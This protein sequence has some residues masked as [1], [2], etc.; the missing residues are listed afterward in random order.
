M[1][2]FCDMEVAEGSIPDIS[3]EK[4]KVAGTVM[5]KVPMRYSLHLSDKN[6]PLGMHS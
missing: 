4:N 1:T 2:F 6:S 5:G 3:D